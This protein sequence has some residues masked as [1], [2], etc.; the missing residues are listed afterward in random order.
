M[1][2]EPLC[3]SDQS[4]PRALLSPTQICPEE[5]HLPPLAVLLGNLTVLLLPRSLPFL[6]V[7]SRPLL[8]SLP[9][10]KAWFLLLLL[11]SAK[12]YG[13]Q[14]T[15]MQN[16]NLLLQPLQCLLLLPG[17]G[18][19]MLPSPMW[20]G[21][22]DILKTRNKEEFQLEFVPYFSLP[23]FPD[24]INACGISLPALDAVQ[25]REAGWCIR[26]MSGCS[27]HCL[28]PKT[29]GMARITWL[30]GQGP[31]PGPS[32]EAGRAG[33][34]VAAN[35][36]LESRA[37][38]YFVVMRQVPPQARKWIHRSGSGLVRQIMVRHSPVITRQVPSDDLGLRS[39]WE[40]SGSRSTRFLDRHRHLC[41]LGTGTQLCSFGD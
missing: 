34:G 40:I 39:S 23:V 10:A 14:G 28:L 9:P 37:S 12:I 26:V 38:D 19:A 21:R 7:P 24:Q 1:C 22:K 18:Q 5:Q 6:P 13:S 31:Q 20:S 16:M 17:L 29:Q 2:A 11:L 15:L 36:S 41:E 35:F 3:L 4:C 8:W 30:Q 33:L 25:T 27:R 32:R